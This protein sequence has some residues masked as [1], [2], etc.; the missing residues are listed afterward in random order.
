MKFKFFIF[1][2][3]MFIEIFPSFS[4]DMDLKSY[5]IPY[6]LT[7]S[8]QLSL[9]QAVKGDYSS[10]KPISELLEKVGK[11]LQ[12]TNMDAFIDS[13]NVDAILIYTIISGNISTL[14][15]LIANDSKG[16]FNNPVVHALRQYHLGNFESAV[17]ELEIIKDKYN[18]KDINPYIY[19]VMANAKMQYSS[20]EAIHYFD[21]VRLLSPGTML[22][23]IALR[24]SLQITLNQGMND[25]SFMYINDYSRK[26][27]HSIYKDQFIKLLF[28]FFESDHVKLQD[29]D[30]FFA[31]SFFDLNDQRNIY[32]Q[33]TRSSVI[34][35][36]IKLGSLTIEKLKSMYNILNCN[37]IATV[38]LY[39]DLINIPF[40]DIIPL[41]YSLYNIPED[42]LIPQ[43]IVLKHASEVII[44]DI[45]LSMLGDDVVDL[46]DKKLVLETEQILNSDLDI[47]P[48]ISKI[49]QKIKEVDSIIDEK[50]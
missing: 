28:L 5:L 9:D 1:T 18:T 14:E 33:I 2:F 30:I 32:L 47:E 46:V 36:N 48:F 50:E 38:W 7:R 43:D 23:E 15:S 26:F 10:D 20:K 13:R 37:D 39:T 16:Y 31:V 49:R 3:I 41:Q 17:K 42:L 11:Q 4:M 24:S 27:S 34:S 6:Y 21:Q 22:E 35:G 40:V 8:L 19:I 25:K 44:S 45:N 29:Y 12:S